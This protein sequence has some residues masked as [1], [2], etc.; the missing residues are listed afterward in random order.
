MDLQHSTVVEC[1]TLE[2]LLMDKGLFHGY[3]FLQP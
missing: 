1:V 3:W 2:L